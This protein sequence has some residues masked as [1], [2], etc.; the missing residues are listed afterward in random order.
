MNE[1]R[2][3]GHPTAGF[4]LLE[5]LVALTVIAV[6]LA[7][8]IKTTGDAANNA[9]YMR[10]KTLAEWVAM[11]Q[12]MRLRAEQAFPDAG[13]S[14]GTVE[15]AGREWRWDREV[16]TYMSDQLR[17]IEIKVRRPEDDK[18]SALTTLTGLLG[19]PD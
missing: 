10:D 17:R 7:A 2:G 1:P 14:H 11:N 15:L 5:V 13:K 8:A 16:E 4:T 6:A 18:D 19:Q 12:L 9:A 3:N